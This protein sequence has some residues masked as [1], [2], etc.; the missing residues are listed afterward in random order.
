MLGDFHLLHELP[1]R[2]TVTGAVL[3]GHTDLLG[4]F[5]HCEVCEGRG[6]ERKA[7]EWLV[8]MMA[9][10]LALARTL[11]KGRR[12]ISRERCRKVVG[13]IRNLD[14]RRRQPRCDQGPHT[15]AMSSA[16]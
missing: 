14:D 11:V 4:T 7:A 10:Q 2:G 16:I 15:H 12:Y 9:I 1:E 5:G 13:S 3:S 8:G 6:N